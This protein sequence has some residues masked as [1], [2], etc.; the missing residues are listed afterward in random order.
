[1]GGNTNRR[2]T[3]RRGPARSGVARKGKELLGKAR[4]NFIWDFVMSTKKEK[5]IYDLAL[6]ESI[7]INNDNGRIWVTRVPGGWIYE[8]PN[9]DDQFSCVFVPFHHEFS[10]Q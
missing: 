10:P 6:H 8:T 9:G 3:A 2:G 1:L 7:G 5:T 4:F